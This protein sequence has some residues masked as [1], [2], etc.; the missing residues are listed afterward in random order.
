MAAEAGTGQHALQHV[1][2]AGVGGGHR[3]TA[4]QRLRQSQRLHQFARRA[5]RIG[6]APAMRL[7]PAISVAPPDGLRQA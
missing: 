1:E 2:R 6:M 4:Q 5:G 3:G 7:A